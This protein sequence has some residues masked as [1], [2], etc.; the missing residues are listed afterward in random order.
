MAVINADNL[1]TERHGGQQHRLVL[2]LDALLDS[3]LEVFD[4]IWNVLDC[5]DGG[6]TGARPN[7][8]RA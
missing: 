6:K 3:L 8:A 2:V 7:I 1:A 4:N 5:A